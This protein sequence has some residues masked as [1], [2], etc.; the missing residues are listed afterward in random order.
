M[1]IYTTDDNPIHNTIIQGM[2]KTWLSKNGFSDYEIRPFNNGEEMLRQA[3]VAK[4]DFVTL[5]INMP[6]L[7][8]LSSLVKFRALDKTTPIIIVSSESESNID[9]HFDQDKCST[10]SDSQKQV[11]LQRVMGRV[12]SDVVEPGKINSVL[13]A[14]ST[15]KMD[16]IKVALSNGANAYIQKPFKIEDVESVLTKVV[17]LN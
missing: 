6:V 15:L 17:N 5:D 8:G 14:V 9:R 3:G 1:I 11:L 13:E 4:P 12:T 7:D 10:M 16:P 2:V